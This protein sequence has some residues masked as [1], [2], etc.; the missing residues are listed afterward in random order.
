MPYKAKFIISFFFK[1]SVGLKGRWMSRWRD[2]KTGRFA[3]SIMYRCTFGIKQMPLNHKYYG[4]T[5]YFFTRDEVTDWG[6]NKFYEVFKE[7]LST[8]LGYGPNEW[9]FSIFESR[10]WMRPLKPRMLGKYRFK[11]DFRGRKVFERRGHWLG[12]PY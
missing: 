1:K 3:K 9:W 5:C 8:Y 10:N 2:V 11:V 6:M 4:V 7:V 12:S